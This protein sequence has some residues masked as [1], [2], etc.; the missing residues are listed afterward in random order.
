MELFGGKN[1]L[2]KH[3]HIDGPLGNQTAIDTG[4]AP[5]SLTDKCSSDSRASR[6]VFDV[7]SSNE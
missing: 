2:I 5:L 1:T 4:Y 7:S 6:V 3:S